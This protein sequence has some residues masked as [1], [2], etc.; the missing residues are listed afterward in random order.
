MMFSFTF[1][2]VIQFEVRINIIIDKRNLLSQARNVYFLS[3]HYSCRVKCTISD[4][5]CLVL[6]THR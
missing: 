4:D 3:V 1:T 6:D 5:K 2:F